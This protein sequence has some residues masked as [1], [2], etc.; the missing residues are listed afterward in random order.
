MAYHTGWGGGGSERIYITE[1]GGREREREKASERASESI[2]VWL[3]AG[4]DWGVGSWVHGSERKGG[5]NGEKAESH[6]LMLFKRSRHQQKRQPV[7]SEKNF[8]VKNS[9]A[10]QVL[11]GCS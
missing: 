7:I 10:R 4:V 3:Y 9:K 2:C 8:L 6:G 11:E 1:G 5:D